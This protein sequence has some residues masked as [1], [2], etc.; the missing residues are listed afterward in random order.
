LT[1]RIL[2]DPSTPPSTTAKSKAL[3]F[4]AK[5][6]SRW[7]N[8][9]GPAKVKSSQKVPEPTRSQV[10]SHSFLTTSLQSANPFTSGFSDIPQVFNISM[11]ERDSSGNPISWESLRSIQSSKGVGEPP[12]FLGSTVFFALREAV[13]AA[14][15]MNGSGDVGLL[16]NAPSTAEKLRLAV[17]DRLVEKAK[18][19]LGRDQPEFF[20]HIED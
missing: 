9:S 6:S 1:F 11:L 15:V 10:H 18:V 8:P 19:V 16:L 17:G 14:R 2:A 5:A 12:L 3:S 7:K 4:K 13:K 20:K